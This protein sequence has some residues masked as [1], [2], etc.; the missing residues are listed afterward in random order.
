MTR[1]AASPSSFLFVAAKPGGGRTFGMRS[2][3]SERQ[4]AEHLRTDKLVLLR[5]GWL[6]LGTCPVRF[7]G[8]EGWVE[9][10]DSGRMAVSHDSLRSELPPPVDAGTAP[11]QH[12]RDFF[13][14]VKSRGMPRANAEVARRSHIACH[15]A[16]IAWSLGRK[17]SFDPVKEVFLGD[18]EANRMCSRA[19]RE[20]WSV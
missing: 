2:A 4:L 14:C 1:A 10:G 11:R 5:T 13:N 7:E 15:A 8:D 18:E 9:T 17:V 3:R 12:V 16:A 19:M 6:G 20:P